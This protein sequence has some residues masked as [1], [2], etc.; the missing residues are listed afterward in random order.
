MID[1]LDVETDDSGIFV[2]AFQIRGSASP[3]VG[4]SRFVT[5]NGGWGLWI[6]NSANPRIENSY[7]LGVQDAASSVARGIYVQDTASVELIGNTA[8]GAL[9]PTQS[10]FAVGL[11]HQSER[12][13]LAVNNLFWIGTA[14]SLT[15][16]SYGTRFSVTTAT[17][18]TAYGNVFAGASVSADGSLSQG[19]S[20]SSNGA[21]V[22]VVLY[23]NTIWAGDVDTAT[24]AATSGLVIEADSMILVNNLFA[25]GAADS[26]VSNGEQLV[27]FNPATSLNYIELRNNGF[28]DASG[29]TNRYY[30]YLTNLTTEAA[31]NDSA[32]STDSTG[33]A[34]GNQIA[35]VD[36]AD[37]LNGDFTLLGTTLTDLRDGGVDVSAVDAALGT[38]LFGNP[39]PGPDGNW[40]I[41]ASE[42][43]GP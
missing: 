43:Q 9:S 10:V 35:V 31:L 6:R 4:N 1:G 37:A 38:D 27:R 17:T 41:G 32:Q 23:N 20:V 14:Q 34:S 21:D 7:M 25:R 11:D 26:R 16:F 42:Y 8:I 3:T 22:D 30:G 18:L 39:R 24:D 12:S 13:V 15:S 2:A 40:S 5:P 19:L 33:P 29:T 36:F 28:S